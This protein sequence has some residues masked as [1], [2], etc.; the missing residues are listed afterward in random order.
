M[1]WIGEAGLTRDTVL[2]FGVIMLMSALGF[3]WLR[4]TLLA[5]NDDD[6]PIVRATSH[7][8]KGRITLISYVAAL[9]MAFVSP[10]AAIVIYLI[11]ALM[12]LIPDKRF[13]GVVG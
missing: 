11:V 9:P 3:A 8:R 10:F 4:S 5:S 12:W 2:A 1:R 13:E 7:G 6:S